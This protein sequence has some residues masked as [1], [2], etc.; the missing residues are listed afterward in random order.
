MAA[1]FSQILVLVTLVSGLIWFFDARFQ[2]PKRREALALAKASNANLSDEAAEALVREPYMVETAHSIFPVIAFVLVLRSFLYEPF[3]IPSGSMMPTLLV[4]DFI[5]V[6]KFSYGI[7]DPVWRKQ[8]INTGDPKRGDIV[9]F[10]YPENP[11]IDYIKRVV[12]LPGDRIFY[13]DKQLYIQRACQEGEACGSVPQKVERVS[14][15][16]GEFSHDG[17]PLLKFR[18]QLGDVTH[19]I[20]INPRRPDMRGMFFHKDGLPTGEFLVPEGH[21]FMMGDNRDNSTDSRFWGFVPEEN[22]VGKAVAIWISFEFERGPGDVLPSWIP[23]GVRFNRVG[24]V[25]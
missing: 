12:G 15:N 22:L 18:E 21:Y 7:K 1:Y 5:L 20:L 3:Q 23:T 4:G 14:V 9:V 8:L 16:S 11:A 19:D 10:K 13:Q 6:E 25:N 2:A 17:V 24:G